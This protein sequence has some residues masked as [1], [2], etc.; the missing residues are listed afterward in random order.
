[1]RTAI[2]IT[3]LITACATPES[4]RED[5]L[6]RLA[7]VNEREGRIRLEGM[8]LV[9]KSSTLA[10]NSLLLEGVELDA[11]GL[12][13]PYAKFLPLVRYTADEVWI[14]TDDQHVILTIVRASSPHGLHEFE[15]PARFRFY[16]PPTLTPSPDD[17]LGKMRQRDLPD[18]GDA[19][20]ESASWPFTFSLQ[21]GG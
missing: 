13:P 2:L 21:R 18:V 6:A 4:P 12:G 19:R 11:Q 1:M 15:G 17:L 3:L 14:T 16:V 5:F 8:Q 10:D 7:A 20:E 9:A